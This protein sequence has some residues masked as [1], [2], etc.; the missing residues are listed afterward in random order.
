MRTGERSRHK[1]PRERAP[2]RK[3]HRETAP[4]ETASRQKA[5]SRQKVARGRPPAAA[6]PTREQTARTRATTRSKS[7]VDSSRQ[8]TA[9]TTGESRPRWPAPEA[10]IVERRNQVAR[11]A[12]R[13]RLAWVITGIA[14]AAVATGAV[15]IAHS[16]LFAS[17]HVVV[18]GDAHTG[19]AAVVNASGL[20][21]STPL[22]DINPGKVA[23]RVEELPWVLHAS[24]TRE[25]PD[26]VR[27]AVTE[28]TPV[29]Y[30][31]SSAGSALFDQA[32]KVLE[33]LAPGSALPA[34]LVPL[35]GVIAPTP[36]ELLPNAD[37]AVLSVAGE[38]PI[39]SL[40]AVTM[41]QRV[42]NLGVVATLHSGAV[43]I[44]GSSAE[45]SQKMVALATLLNSHVLA[46]KVRVDLRVPSSP[47][48]T[49]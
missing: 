24:V 36:G 28:A 17:R 11:D 9:R 32:G 7:E 4:R 25:F 29:A 6:R 37:A 1:A 16:S 10:R 2:R 3:A 41:L 8:Q 14:F 27:I 20:T 39:S 44:F 30:A 46:G 33:V 42:T 47:V 22:Y 13:K 12:G 38:M 19:D 48:L 15:A 21:S 26:S 45:L 49:R 31:T 18:T 5:V 34:H 40:S 43:V 35:G 23:T